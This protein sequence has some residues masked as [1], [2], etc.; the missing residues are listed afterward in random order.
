MSVESCDSELLESAYAKV[1][2]H[3]DPVW[4]IN[5]PDVYQRANQVL[6]VCYNRLWHHTRSFRVNYVLPQNRRQTRSVRDTIPFSRLARYGNY[7][8]NEERESHYTCD[9]E[10]GD[11]RYEPIVCPEENPEPWMLPEVE[12]EF[13]R[14]KKEELLGE[15][16]L[17][18]WTSQ[19][20][21]LRP[22]YDEDETHLGLFDWTSSLLGRH[23]NISKYSCSNE[24]AF[25]FWNLNRGKSQGALGYDSPE[26]MIATA[27]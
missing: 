17:W 14:L 20:S 8:Y 22:G 4:L 13:K 11:A 1:G 9:D 25:F 7:R 19:P 27:W 3:A 12:Q 10:S 6:W 26:R 16:T 15:Y 5:E 21:H 2:L 18:P 24:R 23:E